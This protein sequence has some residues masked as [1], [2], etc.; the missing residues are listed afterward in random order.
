[1]ASVKT[2]SFMRSLCMGEIEQDIILP[3][4]KIQ[5]SEKETLNGVFGAL[6]SWLKNKDAD[7]L[8]N[9]ILDEKLRLSR[10]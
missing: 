10:P 5:E 9:Q 4:P 8:V 1:M 3:F 7:F 6:E 2:K